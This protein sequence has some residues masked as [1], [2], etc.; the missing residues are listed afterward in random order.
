MKKSQINPIF[1]LN[2]DFNSLWHFWVVQA[3]GVCE[4]ETFGS[5]GQ[6]TFRSGA[7]AGKMRRRNRTD[8]LAVHRGSTAHVTSST[9]LTGETRVKSS[10]ALTEQCLAVICNLPYTS[11][12][13]SIVHICLL[14]V[15]PRR[16]FDSPGPRSKS[17]TQAENMTA[18]FGTRG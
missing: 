16:V 6:S 17:I 11:L 13:N 12:F 10:T 1:Y 9:Q 3:E 7:M 8:L 5:D 15:L 18:T 14:S 4:T 2:F